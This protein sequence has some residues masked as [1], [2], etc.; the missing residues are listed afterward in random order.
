MDYEQLISILRKNNNVIAAL[1]FGSRAKGTEKPN[2][3]YDI[4]VFLKD[5]ERPKVWDIEKLKTEIFDVIPDNKLPFHVKVEAFKYGKPIFIKDDEKY[6]ELL[7]KNIVE[8]QDNLHHYYML[9]KYRSMLWTKNM[10][11]K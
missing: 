2:S 8:Y 5:H 1:L 6:T 3:D 9:R 7:Y 4:C 11:Q 10:N